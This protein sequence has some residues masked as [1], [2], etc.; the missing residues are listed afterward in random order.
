MDKALATS[1]RWRLGALLVLIAVVAVLAFMVVLRLISVG[2]LPE[3]IQIVSFGPNPVVHAQPFNQQAGGESAI[4]AK[5]D[6]PVGKEVLVLVLA[7]ERLKTDLDGDLL[8]LTAKVPPQLVSNPGSLQLWIEDAQEVR[9]KPVV[10]EVLSEI[11]AAPANDTGDG[12]PS[13]LTAEDKTIR[14]A[15]GVY[16]PEQDGSRWYAWAG[17]EV[18]ARILAM[19]PVITVHGYMKP[20]MFKQPGGCTLDAFVDGTKAASK[21]YIEDGAIDLSVPVTTAQIGTPIDVRLSSSCSINPKKEN[22]GTDDRTLSFILSEIST[23]PAR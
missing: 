16:Y 11:S 6:R 19:A 22:Q 9:S 4:W 13:R 17:P 3:D 5:V 15:T 18:Q 1:S 23:A 7:G 10:F 8:T 14:R 20:S 21:L 2:T 12:L